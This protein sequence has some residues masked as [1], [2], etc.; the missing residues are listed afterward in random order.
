VDGRGVVFSGR[1]REPICVGLTRPHSARL[2]GRDVWL[3]NSGYGEVGLVVDG[4]FQAVRRLPGW[5]RG[6]CVV[7]GFAFV[8]TS[9]VLPRFA[10]YAPGLDPYKCHS[11]IHAL[12]IKTG[13]LVASVVWPAGNQVFALD[14]L[15]SGSTAGFPWEKS[16]GASGGSTV[17]Y[18]YRAH[19][20]RRRDEKP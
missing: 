10:R 18:L 17:F 19:S 11:G 1:S 14:W 16:A 2:V 5:T 8:G 13:R 15:A 12:E 7:G 4:R 3:D 9:R 20:A 6:L